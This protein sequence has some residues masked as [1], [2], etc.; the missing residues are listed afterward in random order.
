MRFALVA[1]PK[2]GALNAINHHPFNSFWAAGMSASVA[3][4]PT[5]ARHTETTSGTA[6]EPHVPAF[7]WQ[8]RATPAHSA[9]VAART[10]TVGGLAA[11]GGLAGEA[12]RRRAMGS[13]SLSLAR[14]YL[15]H[16]EVMKEPSLA[17]CTGL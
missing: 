6:A 7:S 8:Y 13:L 5:P 3:A 9:A 11:V 1:L 2:K 16:T 4:Q 15:I 17:L 12:L 14:R 10:G